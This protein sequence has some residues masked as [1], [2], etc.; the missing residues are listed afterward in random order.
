MALWL[1]KEL[2]EKINKKEKYGSVYA[3]AE[4]LNQFRR[5]IF[6]QELPEPVDVKKEL[7]Y[8]SHA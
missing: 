8:P 4:K 3:T 2:L 7:H 5:G 6:T 1:P